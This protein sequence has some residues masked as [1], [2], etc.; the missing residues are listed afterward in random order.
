MKMQRQEDTTS[1]YAGLAAL[2]VGG[3][4][5][6]HWWPRIKGWF[7]KSKPTSPKGTKAKISKNTTEGPDIQSEEERSKSFLKMMGKFAFNNNM[8]EMLQNKIADFTKDTKI[9]GGLLKFTQTMSQ[10]DIKFKWDTF[11][12]AAGKGGP[13][14]SLL[15]F[16]GRRRHKSTSV[17]K[18]VMTPTFK[19]HLQ[20]LPSIMTEHRRGTDT[21]RSNPAKLTAQAEAKSFFNMIGG[22]QKLND[23]AG[24]GG[25]TGLLNGGKV[26]G[27]L[28][29]GKVTGLLDGLGG[30]GIGANILDGLGGV[31]IGANILGGLGGGGI[32]GA[33]AAAS[34]AGVSSLI[35]NKLVGN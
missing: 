32:M 15:D 23:L 3:A 24:L 9:E 2:T 8:V 33:I 7:S 17:K 27:L 31:G 1:A 6:Y 16:V 12:K 26:T 18:A 21:S 35:T 34:T 4:A 13:M 28:N 11:K 20:E 19:I 30:G 5:L 14:R 10:D 22:H 29:G 25:V